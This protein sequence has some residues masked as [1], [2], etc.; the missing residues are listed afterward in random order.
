MKGQGNELTQARE[1][2]Y[3]LEKANEKSLHDRDVLK[4][5]VKA[6]EDGIY[7]QLEEIKSLQSRLREET[8]TSKTNRKEHNLKESELRR[9]VGQ[10]THNIAIRDKDIIELKNQLK[11]AGTE[12]EQM[13][14]SYSEDGASFDRQIQDLESKNIDLE[15]KVAGLTESLSEQARN[16]SAEDSYLRPIKEHLDTVRGHMNEYMRVGDHF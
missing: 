3:N 12:L 1:K 8:E 2:I 13:K 4:N 14:K 10:L 15:A 5:S 7:K 9:E 11:V 16:H 6:K